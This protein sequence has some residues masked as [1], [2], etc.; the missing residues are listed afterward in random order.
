M[1]W[2]AASNNSAKS[3]QC[4]CANFLRVFLCVLT[5]IQPNGWQI[6]TSRSNCGVQRICKVLLTSPKLKALF[7][8]V[9]IHTKKIISRD[10]VSSD[11]CIG[12]SYPHK[13]EPAR[14]NRFCRPRRPRRS[15]P[16]N[17]NIQGGFRRPFRA[18]KALQRRRSRRQRVR[19][20]A[21]HKIFTRLNDQAR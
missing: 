19:K 2:S 15:K 11:R 9:F 13:P 4:V 7:L 12:G 20:S 17:K 18:A 10:Q 1:F 3:N 5:H 14:V 16:V 6:D 21:L 8:G